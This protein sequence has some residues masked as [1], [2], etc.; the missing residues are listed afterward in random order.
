MSCGYIKMGD[1]TIIK[2]M[3]FDHD[4]IIEYSGRGIIS[5]CMF[6]RN[7]TLDAPFTPNGDDKYSNRVFVSNMVKG[8]LTVNGLIDLNY[9]IIKGKPVN[10]KNIGHN[11]IIGEEQQPSNNPVIIEGK[12]PRWVMWKEGDIYYCKNQDTGVVMNSFNCA[13]LVNKMLEGTS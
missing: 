12:A 2:N 1:E 7:V 13:W 11:I 6:Y 5:E 3:W 8:N 10:I 9:N 4:V